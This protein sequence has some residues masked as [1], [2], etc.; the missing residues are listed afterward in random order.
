MQVTGSP[1]CAHNLATAHDLDV[2]RPTPES[3]KS[4]MKHMFH[5]L[6]NCTLIWNRDR[7]QGLL[8]HEPFRIAPDAYMWTRYLE[9]LCIQY[10]NACAIDVAAI[11]RRHQLAVCRSLCCRVAA[12]T[13]SLL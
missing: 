1:A 11:L 8:P 5:R 9:F 6:F 3:R 2:T 4:A 10:K 7:H 13:G 12:V